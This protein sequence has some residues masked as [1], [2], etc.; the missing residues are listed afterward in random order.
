MDSDG[1]TVFSLA[2]LAFADLHSFRLWL[3]FLSEVFTASLQ[4]VAQYP[5][6]LLIKDAKHNLRYDGELFQQVCRSVQPPTLDAL[7][8]KRYGDWLSFAEKLSQGYPLSV[9]E[10]LAKTHSHET[11]T[12]LLE[13][14]YD[15]NFM[16]GVQPVWV[17]LAKAPIPEK[18]WALVQAPCLYYQKQDNELLRLYEFS[19]G[20]EGCISWLEC[21]H[22]SAYSIAPALSCCLTALKTRVPDYTRTYL[23]SLWIQKNEVPLYSRLEHHLESLL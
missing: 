4:E 16:S 1:Q 12:Y 18:C 23:E 14:G 15:S 21:L 8:K 19:A 17:A 7:M 3:N 6:F 11:L 2:G 5:H 13:L 9:V 20:E 22:S 10:L